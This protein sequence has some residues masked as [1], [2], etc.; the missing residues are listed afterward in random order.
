MERSGSVKSTRFPLLAQTVLRYTVK[1]DILKLAANRTTQLA[2]L[3]AAGEQAAF[4][5]RE[6]GF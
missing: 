1:I 5:D 6:G 3:K 4:D 2:D